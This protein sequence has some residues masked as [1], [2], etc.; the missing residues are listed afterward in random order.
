M[1]LKAAVEGIITCRC[2]I[3][4]R[5]YKENFKIQEIYIMDWQQVWQTVQD[6]LTNTGIKLLIAIAIMIVSFA[7]IN[8][9]SKKIAKRADKKVEENKKIDKT[10]YKTVSYVVKVGLKVLVVLGLI[11]YVGIDTS[12]ITALIASLGVGVGLAI[13]GTLSNFAGGVLILITRPFKDDD[14]IQACGYEGTVE[15]IR[16]CHTRLRTTDNKVVYLPNGK[17]STS[18]VVNFSEKDLRRVDL[19]FSISYSD[20]FE[21]AKTIIRKVCDANELVLKDPE[22]SVRV[23]A[24]SSSS[25]DISAKVWCKNADYWTVNFDMIENVKKAFDENGITIPFNQL[26]VHVV[27]DVTT[28]SDDAVA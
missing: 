10:I 16:I 14:Y 20:D 9:L 18:E 4:L 26:D 25:I 21:K 1:L 27:S 28:K 24:Q 11:S 5:L 22:P 7:L 6:W 3:Y 17:L 2:A 19:K 8:W 15:D 12:A 13:N 23:S